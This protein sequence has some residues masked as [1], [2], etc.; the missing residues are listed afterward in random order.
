MNNA[1]NDGDDENSWRYEMLTDTNTPPGVLSLCEIVALVKPVA[2]IK[3][4][5]MMGS[6]DHQQN[7]RYVINSGLHF[8]M[9]DHLSG[10]QKID[11]L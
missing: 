2:A 9:S 5:L 3:V 7:H 11:I 1:F 4:D 10:M 8:V 6:D